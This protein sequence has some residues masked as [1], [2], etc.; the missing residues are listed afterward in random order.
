MKAKSYRPEGVHTITP[1][2][3]VRNAEKALDFYKK[4]FGAKETMRMPG[5][6]GKTIIHAEMLIGDSHVYLSDE[7]P[8]MGALSPQSLNGVPASMH[9]YV[10]NVD[11]AFSKALAAGCEVKMPVGDMFW[12]DRYGK[13]TDPFGH[14][15]GIATH[16]EDLTDDEIISRQKEWFAQMA[17]AKA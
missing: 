16:K 13:V 15:W 12:G 14:V 7:F 6:D 8:E 10:E 9:M 2:L 3:V 1:H 11:D 5:P 17:S 4:A